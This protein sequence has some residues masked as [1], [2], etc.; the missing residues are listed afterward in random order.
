M[1]SWFLI[2]CKSRQEV[3]AE[4]NLVRQGFDVFRPTINVVK[5][6]IGCQNTVKSEPLFPG[7]LFIKVDPSVK[8]IGPVHSTLGVSNF[9]KFGDSYAVASDTLIDNIKLNVDRQNVFTKD[10]H[11]L[12]SGDE[13]YVHGH[14]F[15]QVKAI[16]C[17]ACG[18][19]RAIIL[20]TILG[21]ESKL[22][23]PTNCLSKI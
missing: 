10:G 14:G 18:Y 7:Y 2:Y 12:K 6:K 17:N 23:V 22:M 13:I 1:S 11:S 21:R 15:D 19:E 20:M 3:R 4:E 9:V 5:A 8:S 16:Y